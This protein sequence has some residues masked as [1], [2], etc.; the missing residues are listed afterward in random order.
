MEE[1]GRAVKLKWADEVKKAGGDPDAI[2][3]AASL[4]YPVQRG[5]LTAIS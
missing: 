3:R 4:P 1:V 2:S 5:L